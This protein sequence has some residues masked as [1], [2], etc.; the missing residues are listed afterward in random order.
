MIMEGILKNW[1]GFL[2]EGFT[3]QGTPDLK[4][5][6]FDWDD[7]VVFMPTQIILLDTQGKEVQRL[8]NIVQGKAGE[9]TLNGVGYTKSKE[10][11]EEG[12]IWTENGSTYVSMSDG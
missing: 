6:A 1:R 8:R 10:F 9:R 4:Y 3:E 11:Y 7:N 5:Y 2:N 12:D